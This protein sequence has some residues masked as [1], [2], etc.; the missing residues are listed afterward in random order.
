[1]KRTPDVARAR[2]LIAASEENLRFTRTLQVTRSSTPTIIRNTYE[3]FRM[4]GQAILYLR[5]NPSRHHSIQVGVLLELELSGRRPLRSIE[6]LRELRHA[7][8]Y[9]GYL[10]NEDEARDALAIADDLYE[11]IVVE[12]NKLIRTSEDRG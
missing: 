5:G 8:N 12:A 10:P 6:R 3:S 7:I 4:I 9:Q 1:M 2:S 11:L